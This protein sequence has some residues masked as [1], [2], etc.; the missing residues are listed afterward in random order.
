[1][2]V[3]IYGMLWAILAIVAGLTFVTGNMTEIAGVAFGFV[4]FGLI[5]MGMISVLPF[6]ISHPNPALK[7][8]KILN[9]KQENRGFAHSGTAS[10]H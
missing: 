5:F 4:V 7:P 3:K 1:M 10:V 6:T 8:V 9:A 2:I